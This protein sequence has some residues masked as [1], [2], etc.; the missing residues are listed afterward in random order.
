MSK[1]N[2]DELLS[3]LIKYGNGKFSTVSEAINMTPKLGNGETD[4]AG[5]IANIDK[6]L[7]REPYQNLPE[8]C[9]KLVLK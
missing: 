3:A 6:I 5:V 8:D 7:G 2:S 4:V 1:I 9:K